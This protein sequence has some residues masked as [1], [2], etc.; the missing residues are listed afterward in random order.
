MEAT[1]EILTLP[2]V[3]T[4]SRRR[5]AAALMAA[6]LLLAACSGGSDSGAPEAS[7]TAGA[8]PSPTPTN[9][10]I[11]PTTAASPLPETGNILANPGFEDGDEPWIS[12]TE[13]TGFQ[14]TEERAHS[15]KASA[16]L[17]MRDG[18]EAEGSTVYYLVQE[19]TP[20]KFPEVVRGYYRVE[21]WK[22]GTLKQ[23]LQ[24]VV[25]AWEPDNFPT[26]APNWQI[27][28]PLAGID[29]PPFLIGNA[30]F[31]FIGKEEPVEGEWVKFETNVE[32]D[33]ERLWGQ[34]PEGFEFL[35]ILFEVRFDGA[36]AAGS[37]AEADVY[38]D[39]L[40]FGPAD[41]E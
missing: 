39:D 32:D 9:P 14:R 24:F 23:Y 35:R 16:L 26:D 34:A 12:L 17:R 13:D 31:V 28:Y 40:Y 5:L 27:R 21:N 4:A 18:P 10:S 19:V 41:A 1:S 15:G 33:F 7:P 3:S 22:K 20:T 25:I 8:L 30:H 6:A 2:T 29:S 38:Y 36:I 37:S 11:G